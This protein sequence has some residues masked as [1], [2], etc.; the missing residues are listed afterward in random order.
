[1]NPQDKIRFA[2]FVGVGTT[3]AGVSNA[4]DCWVTYKERSD[5]TYVGIGTSV[6]VTGNHT[7]FTAVTNPFSVN[8]INLTNYSDFVD[9]DTSVSIFRFGTIRQGYLVKDLTIPQNST[10]QILQKEKRIEPTDAIVV[11]AGISSGISVNLSGR[12][13]T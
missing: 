5:T 7:V 13:I 1:M 6:G 10:V 11:E 4:V 3:S 8:V 2:S 9:I 12:Y